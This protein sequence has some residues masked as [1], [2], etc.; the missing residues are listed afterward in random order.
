MWA[1]PSAIMTITVCLALSVCAVTIISVIVQSIDGSGNIGIALAQT[2]DNTSATN[3]TTTTANTNTSTSSIDTFRAKGQISCLVSDV[4]AGRPSGNASEI[5]VLSGNWQF[6]VSKG[7]LTNISVNI[8][9]TKIDGKGAHHHAIEN[10]RN[11]T[12]AVLP[13]RSQ[14]ITLTRG[15]YTDFKGIADITT[16]GKLKWKDVPI[17]INMLNGN[18]INI[19]INPKKTDDHFKGL[20]VFGTVKSIID[21]NGNEL[22]KRQQQ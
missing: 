16:N 17:V 18:I 9:M 4:L 12:G 22:L 20:P 1:I 14:Q 2:K 7:N 6:G 10:L 21:K 13:G 3:I 5:W 15:N 19:H 8:L 11:A